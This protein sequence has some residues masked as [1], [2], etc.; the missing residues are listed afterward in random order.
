MSSLNQITIIGKVGGI[1]TIVTAQGK[2]IVKLSV[3][4]SHNYKDKNGDWVDNTEWHRAVVSNE[5]IVDVVEKYGKGDTIF[6]QGEIRTNK[7]TTKDGTEKSELQI[8]VQS[9]KK[10]LTAPTKQGDASSQRPT[11]SAPAA[12]EDSMDFIP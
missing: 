10:M 8:W 3:A 5:K 11:P 2:K 4:T 6:F 7:Y 12:Q 9:I 1:D